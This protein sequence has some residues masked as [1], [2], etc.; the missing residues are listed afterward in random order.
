MTLLEV[1]IGGNFLL[2]ILLLIF[3]EGK[4]NRTHVNRLVRDIL[5]DIV[6]SINLILCIQYK[7]NITVAF[8]AVLLLLEVI[9]T[10][11]SALNIAKHKDA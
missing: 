11:I 9:D 7:S 5:V 4:F 8:V 6:L 2:Y 10:I 1:A 3:L